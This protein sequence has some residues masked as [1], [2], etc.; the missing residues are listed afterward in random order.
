MEFVSSELTAYVAGEHD[1]DGVASLA[2]RVDTCSG[3]FVDAN[4]FEDREDSGGTGNLPYLYLQSGA[5]VTLASFTATDGGEHILVAWETASEVDNQ[6]F[7]LYRS[8]SPTGMDE[9]SY[10]QL[11]DSLIPNEAPAPMEGASYSYRD[12]EVT[13]GMTYY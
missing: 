12:D 5:A 8:E 3:D 2:V 9:G 13:R 11:D 1:G 6:G 7:N 10:S 4:V